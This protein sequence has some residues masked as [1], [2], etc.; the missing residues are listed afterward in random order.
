M[1]LRKIVILGATGSIGDNTLEVVRGNPER[2]KVVGIAGKSNYKKL[3]KIAAEFGVKHVA[4][5]DEHAFNEA[6]ASGLFG[7]AKLYRGPEGLMEISVLPEADTVVA[8]VVGTQALKPTLAAIEAGKDIALAN[9]ELLVMA[10]KFV[11]GAAKRKGVK[12]LPLDSEHNAIFQCLQ[13]E[14]MRDVSKLLIT[15]SGG[16]FREYTLEQMKAIR[17]EDALKH[18]NWKMGPKVTIDSSTLAN[19][20]LEVIEAKWLFGVTPDQ[21]QVVVQRQSLIH[22]MVQ[23]SDGS[24]VAHLSPPSMT[25]A[26]SHSLLCPERGAPVHEPLDFT[27]A[28][29]IDFCP[30][31]MEKFPCLK[32][33]FNSLRM[34]GTASTVFNASNEIAVEEFIAGRLPWLQIPTVVGKTLDAVAVIEPETLDDVL[35]VDAE[36]R[37]KARE[38]AQKI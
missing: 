16:M 6:K 11:M 33:A 21:I 23:F 26:I 37:V 13:G 38:I 28:F 15:A 4:I 34:G 8:A 35:A 32:H 1:D 5:Y 3:A 36:A 2:L 29:A 12:M 27:K 31:D 20:G 22:S 24:V 18:P 7:G 30:P 10:G 19:K 25:F 14:C 17:P 9:K